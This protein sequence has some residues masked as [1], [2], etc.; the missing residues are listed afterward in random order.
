MAGR[1]P[2]EIWEASAEEGERR[3]ER[4]PIGMFVTGW[5]GGA[6]ALVLQR[7]VQDPAEYVAT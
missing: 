2:E 1:T 3:L 6:D 5:I 7:E 4:G